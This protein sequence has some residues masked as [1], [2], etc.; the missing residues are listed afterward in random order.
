MPMYNSN[1]REKA[2]KLLLVKGLTLKHQTGLRRLVSEENISQIPEIFSALI[3]NLRTLGDRFF[4]E[5]KKYFNTR[6]IIDFGFEPE[7]DYNK[8]LKDIEKKSKKGSKT[9]FLPR[10]MKLGG[11]FY[12]SFRCKL[13]Q[14]NPNRWLNIVSGFSFWLELANKKLSKSLYAEIEGEGLEGAEKESTIVNLPKDANSCY[15]KLLPLIKDVI[16]MSIDNNPHMGGHFKRPLSKLGT[17]I[18]RRMNNI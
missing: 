17:D 18:G 10:E 1:L 11:N 15:I 6:P 7:Y 5:F 16:E 12:I 2:L 3:G 9:D 4:F 13:A 8:V 14:N